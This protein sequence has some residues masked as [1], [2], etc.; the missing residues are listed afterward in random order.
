MTWARCYDKFYECS[1]EITQ[2]KKLSLVENIGPEDEVAEVMLAF[3]FDHEAT[4]NR[5]TTRY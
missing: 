4:V 1:E 5:E 3:A 2:I